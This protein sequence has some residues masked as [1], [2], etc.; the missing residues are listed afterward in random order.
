MKTKKTL[1]EFFQATDAIKRGYYKLLRCI[2][3]YR[4]EVYIKEAFDEPE[5]PILLYHY[6]VPKELLEQK[7][8]DREYFNSEARIFTLKVKDYL[9]V[10]AFRD[11]YKTKQL[12]QELDKL[13]A[14]IYEYYNFFQRL[15]ETDNDK[16]KKYFSINWRLQKLF[17]NDK[18][19]KSY[20]SNDYYK[21]SFLLTDAEIDFYT[22]N[23]MDLIRSGY[24]TKE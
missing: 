14:K 23:Y 18:V 19:V 20:L 3:E 5:F 1:S 12:K 7:E 15:S 17:P 6:L 22:Q 13:S 11:N 21:K 10:P 9:N 24:K 4:D 16:N 2:E 8:K